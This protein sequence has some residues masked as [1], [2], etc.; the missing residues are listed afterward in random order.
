MVGAR[1]LYLV[2][3]GETDWN[4]EGRI[5][6]TIDV[7]L[8]ERGRRQAACLAAR[9]K[10]C[11]A[12]AIYTSPLLRALETAQVIAASLGVAVTSEPDLRERDFGVWQG[13]LAS[14]LP[15]RF[16]G[17]LARLRADAADAFPPGGE[18]FRQLMF[19]VAKA[20]DH[21]VRTAPDVDIVIVSHGG[22]THAL[23][24]HLLGIDPAH[25]SRF[26]VDNAS[27]TTAEL[28]AA[29]TRLLLLNDTCHLDG[30]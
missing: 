28:A 11:G 27:L 26:V 21:L 7:P 1:K 10:R 23:L 18:S 17:E 4:I 5:Q 20:V 8:N 6:G 30:A 16:P 12:G 14:E 24:C 15:I 2:R 13:L 22:T 19:R 3:H 9:L 29:G 25:R